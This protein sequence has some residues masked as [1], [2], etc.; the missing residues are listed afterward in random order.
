MNFEENN[1]DSRASGVGFNNLPPKP[2]TNQTA[3]QGSMMNSGPLVKSDYDISVKG[4][5]SIRTLIR[6]ANTR[7]D[8]VEKPVEV[9]KL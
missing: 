1:L 7:A 9:S 6:L 5:S 3:R 8:A 4:N 2:R